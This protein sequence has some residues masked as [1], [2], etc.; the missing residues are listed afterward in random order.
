MSRHYAIFMFFFSIV[1]L[2]GNSGRPYERLV[3]ARG[4]MQK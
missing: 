3:L 2:E 1:D 4:A